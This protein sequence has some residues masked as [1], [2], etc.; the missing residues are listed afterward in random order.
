M[1]PNFQDNLPTTLSGVPPDFVRHPAQLI[2]IASMVRGTGGL[3]RRRV[4]IGYALQH[5]FDQALL[6][7]S[8]KALHESAPISILDAAAP[9]TI[10]SS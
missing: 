10:L 3:V 2:R 8:V 9:L 4:R 6:R 5:T 7:Y 1:A